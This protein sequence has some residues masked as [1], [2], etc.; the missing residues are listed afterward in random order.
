MKNAICHRAKEVK[1]MSLSKIERKIREV[2]LDLKVL[3]GTF[4]ILSLLFLCFI[5]SHF[6]Y[7]EDKLDE[8]HYVVVIHEKEG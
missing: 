1:D 7:I 3:G 2:G 5:R 4:A 8:I 6:S